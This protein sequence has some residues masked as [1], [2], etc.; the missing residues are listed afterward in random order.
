MVSGKNE[1][2][3]TDQLPAISRSSISRW[4][5]RAR[6][7]EEAVPL[8]NFFPQI[9]C[10]IAIRIV[11]VASAGPIA[12]VEREKLSFFALQPSCHVDLVGVYG[13]VDECA[14]LELEDR[15]VG[16]AVILVLVFVHPRQ[17]GR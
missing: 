2:L 17:F 14:F 16:I 5:N 3:F 8:P 13:K 9:G 4:M 6:D 1:A 7:V 11:R 15:F 12:L 10:L